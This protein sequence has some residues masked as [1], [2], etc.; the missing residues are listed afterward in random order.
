[1]PSFDAPISP[2]AAKHPITKAVRGIF[3]GRLLIGLAIA[4][5]GI[6]FARPH[7]LW[8][9]WAPL[10]RS[11]SAALVFTGLALRFWAGGSAGTHTHSGEIEA[12]QLATGGPYAYVRNPIYLGSII[13]GIGMVG[14]I[15]DPWML[16]FCALAF[17]ALYLVIIPAEERFLQQ[18]FGEAYTSYRHAVP[19]L[20]PRLRRWK[21]GT[22]RRF[23][24]HVAR[25]E[26]RIFIVLVVIYA[27][28]EWVAWVRGA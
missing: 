8:G 5:V 17:I 22:Q 12:P 18:Q 7:T 10:G 27:A 1:M 20:V 25:G 11:C 3:A 28:M 24:W 14:L 19:R 26:L 2:A 16:P 21:A 15:G 23:G 9:E 13:L 4:A 6:Y